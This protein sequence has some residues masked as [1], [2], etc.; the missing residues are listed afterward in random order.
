MRSSWDATWLDMAESLAHNRSLCVRS[1][2]G[3]IV[4][5]LD[6]R[7]ASV[8]YNGPPAGLNLATPCSDW[9]P[10]G[11][12]TTPGSGTGFALNCTVHAEV[13]A[14]MRA[15]WSEMQLGTI[16]VTRSPCR[17]CARMI[18][19]SG[20]GRA[21]FPVKPEDVAYGVDEI[22]GFI[23]ECGV[24]VLVFDEVTNL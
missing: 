13:N 8:G 3:A 5:T 11:R 23:Q 12:N 15:N 2:V 6:N 20:L 7:V 9:C 22:A 4:V 10:T 14:L 24:E 1:Q 18:G 16:Y 21:V 17:D 19:N